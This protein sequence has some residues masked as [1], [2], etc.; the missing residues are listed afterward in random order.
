MAK[1]PKDRFATAGALAAAAREALLA[2][3]P[4]PQMTELPPPTGT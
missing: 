4:I 3:P 1:D 2:E